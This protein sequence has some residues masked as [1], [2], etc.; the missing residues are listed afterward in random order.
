MMDLPWFPK[1]YRAIRPVYLFL[2]IIGALFCS[3]RI[4][5]AQDLPYRDRLIAAAAEKKLA[6]DRYWDILVHYRPSGS[7]RESLIDDPKFFLA[8]DGKSDPSA[9][10]N[11]TI[12]GF[13]LPAELGDEHPQCRFVA[14]Y[15]WLKEQLDIDTSRLPAVRCAKYEE[16]MAH[17]STRS[18]SLIFPAA[19]GNGPA[20]MFGHTLIR[21]ESPFQSKLLTFAVN[22]AADA[23][24]TNG[25]LYAFKGIFGFYKGYYSILP[26]YVKVNEYNH[27]EHRDIWEYRLNLSPQEVRRMVMHIWELRD[28]Y[29]DYYFFT[30]NCS[31]NL[32]YLLEAARPSLHL[33]DQFRERIRFWVIPTDTVRSIVASGL[34]DGITYRPS[35]ATR[36]TARTSDMSRKDQK[37][38]LN[39]VNETMK[40]ADLGMTGIAEDEEKK[41]LDL[42]TEVVQYRY[43]RKDMGKKEYLGRFLPI[44]SARSALTGTSDEAP[45]I[46]PPLSPDHGHLPGR[47]GV[48]IGRRDHDYFGEVSWRA[49][50]HD[51]MDPTD[52]YVDGAQIN[53]FDIHIRKYPDQRK[54]KLQ[55]FHLLDIFSLAPRDLFFKPVSWKVLVGFEQSIL[56]DRRDHLVLRLSPGG[57]AAY[58]SKAL[59]LTYIM[60]ESDLQASRAFK[61]GWTAGVG[62]SGGI[63]RSITPA[64][65]LDLSAKAVFYPLGDTH[66]TRAGRFR[67]SVKFSTNTA[68]ELDLRREKTFR[69]YRTDAV[70][71]LNLYY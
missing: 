5:A 17:I 28:I 59:G 1:V 11:S 67:T 61:S 30:E 16:S 2:F 3:P 10:L 38:A 47:I 62:V 70:A 34:V 43:S 56:P 15:A 65:K 50:Y 52:G 14:R 68:L 63:Y 39:I 51:L 8:A 23:K 22:Y 21:I 41:V 45:V 44:L 37:L 40:P 48:G 31:Y 66:R 57:G 13:F 29:S 19:H 26:Y 49:A 6:A 36:I 18:A 9:E 20:S 60:L 69:Q 35:L 25:F 4:A 27:I 54:A 12:A 46:T 42:A 24:D 33:V 32:L 58:E 55:A 7:G 64:W 71:S 53:F